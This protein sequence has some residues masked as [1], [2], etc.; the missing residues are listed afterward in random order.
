MQRSCVKLPIR[1][2]VS[3]G[4]AIDEI[5]RMITLQLQGDSKS[6]L[7]LARCCKTWSSIAVALLWAEISSEQLAR[8]ATMRVS[9]VA[10]RIFNTHVSQDACIVTNLPDIYTERLRTTRILVNEAC[11]GKALDVW[12]TLPTFEPRTVICLDSTQPIHTSF[13]TTRITTLIL[14]HDRGIWDT[15]WLSSFSRS[16]HNIASSLQQLE[17]SLIPRPTS[18][19]VIWQL[20]NLHALRKLKLSCTDEC[21][22][23]W[24][25]QAPLSNAFAPTGLL[26]IEELDI[27]AP[28]PIVRTILSFTGSTLRKLRI[29]GAPFDSAE[30]VASLFAQISEGPS[31]AQITHLRYGISNRWPLVG[32]WEDSLDEWGIPYLEPETTRITSDHLQ[33]LL[34][35][36]SLSH[37][38][39][40][41][42]TRP[43]THDT[44][45]ATLADK[46]F[47]LQNL[48]ISGRDHTYETSPFVTLQ[49]ALLLSRLPYLS[50]LQLPLDLDSDT[51]TIVYH[52]FASLSRLGV[53]SCLAPT[54]SRIASDLAAIFPNV[55]KVYVRAPAYDEVPC[56]A[57]S[58]VWDTWQ[59][60]QNARP[61]VIE[62]VVVFD[63]DEQLAE[64]DFFSSSVR[65]AI[66]IDEA[67]NE[68]IDYLTCEVDLEEYYTRFPEARKHPFVVDD[69]IYSSP[70]SL[71]I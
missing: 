18:I 24:I 28:V 14:A 52:P 68:S 3:R 57:W 8:I 47:L 65:D 20:G 16:I 48:S 60:Y 6:L 2:A 34:R 9:K 64:D 56:D 30:L 5:L 33:P 59:Q 1:T 4:L 7:A 40:T 44:F 26:S 66:G 21:A 39:L 49:S 51:P 53:M 54:D 41:F 19:A 11:S 25:Q 12:S 67:E 70:Q 37:L 23:S 36:C 71:S 22:Q 55:R 43:R 31:A 46:L 27:E 38:S 45:L 50:A 29:T 32:D 69:I 17:I 35:L 13:L 61:L 10:S 63:E 42:H 15:N 62:P 58:T